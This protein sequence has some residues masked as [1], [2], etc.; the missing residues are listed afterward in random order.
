VLLYGFCST[1]VLT[2][3]RQIRTA[4]LVML[5]LAAQIAGVLSMIAFAYLG[6]GVW[7]LVVGNL[8]SAA[9][10]TVLSFA[11]PGTHRDGFGID[12]EAR[13]EIILFGRWILA[14]SALTF[15]V[16]RGDQLALARLLGAQSLGFYNLAFALSEALDNVAQ[17]VIH[18]VM[19]PLFAQLH[20]EAPEKLKQAYYHARLSFDLVVQLGLG[21]VCALSPLVIDVL[22]DDRYRDAGPMLRVLIVRVAVGLMLTPCEVS[23]A[24]QGLSQ[25]A[26]RRTVAMSLGMLVGVPVGYAWGGALGL[27]WGT[28]LA[29]L[30]VFLVLWP[31]AHERGLL[32]VTRELLAALSFLFGAALGALLLPWFS[33]F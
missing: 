18:G 16:N 5:E 27:L 9:V 2:L 6:F 33:R 31:A 30:P 15:G 24:A 14:S 32:S 17:R 1:R 13:K 22:Y 25:Y 21:G 26:F 19:Y 29:R 4:P 10:H 8:L 23:L 20:N 3:R 11:L 12:P 28:V 7:S